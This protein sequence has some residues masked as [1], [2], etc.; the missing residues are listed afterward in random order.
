MR[1]FVNE[2]VE[3]MERPY[4][5][6]WWALPLHDTPMPVR[7]ADQHHAK[8][9]DKVTRRV[10]RSKEQVWSTSEHK[11]AAFKVQ[12]RFSWSVTERHLPGI[13]V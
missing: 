9:P 6:R 5:Q 10:G 3:R 11:V 1:L 12:A 8:R 13:V 4:A 2:P 7:H